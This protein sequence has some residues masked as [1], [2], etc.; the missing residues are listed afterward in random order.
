MQLPAVF[1]STGVR[2]P[3]PFASIILF[4]KTA[5]NITNS[6][7]DCCSRLVNEHKTNNEM[8]RE[9]TMKTFASV[10]LTAVVASGV[11]SLQVAAA[12]GQQLAQCQNQVVE[13][14]DG[15]AD[16]RYVSQRRFRDGTQMKFA[17]AVEDSS[18]G[19]KATRLATCWLG[20]EN[21]Q[22]A[23]DT[24]AEIT[25]ADIYDSVT[26]SIVVPLQP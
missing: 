13:Y 12:D 22:A 21:M 5:P 9:N 15:V 2:L 8:N 17:V 20:S 25:V 1:R 3:Y 11:C 14:Y 10:V 23:A 16:V 26:D 19:Y 6:S 18:T 7:L 24:G 4:H